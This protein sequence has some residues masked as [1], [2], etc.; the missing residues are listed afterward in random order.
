MTGR[1]GSIF[2]QSA[3]S[4]STHV[5]GANGPLPNS[6]EDS[7]YLYFLMKY[8]SYLNK[9]EAFAPI[10]REY[11]NQVESSHHVHVY[12]VRTTAK[13]T[14]PTWINYTDTYG[15]EVYSNVLTANGLTE[16]TDSLQHMVN[17]ID[18]IFMNYQ[19]HSIAGIDTTDNL[20]INE[21]DPP[22][23]PNNPF[24]GVYKRLVTI[25]VKYTVEYMF[26]LELDWEINH[27]GARYSAGTFKELVEDDIY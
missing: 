21:V 22:E 27:Y 5:L 12:L 13:K 6:W 2:Q 23:T 8:S 24:Q 4:D 19:S 1:I 17:E 11:S 7:L 14:N 9:A 26:P 25:D 20:V 3:Y 16:A 15:F 18:R 10:N